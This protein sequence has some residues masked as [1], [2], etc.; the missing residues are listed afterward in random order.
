[1]FLLVNFKRN[2]ALESIFYLFVV[3]L[4]DAV[5]SLDTIPLNVQ[6]VNE[7]LEG[8]WKETVVAFF[9]VLSWH[10][11]RGTEKTTKIVGQ[12]IRSLGRDFNPRPPEYE[13]AM[14]TSRALHSV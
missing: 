11:P 14:L 6:I 9:N 10:L 8:V 5:T 1:M 7:K 13:A 12:D 2:V 4:N 3:C